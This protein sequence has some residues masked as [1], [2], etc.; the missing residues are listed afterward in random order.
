MRMRLIICLA[1]VLSVLMPSHG[2]ADVI[3]SVLDRGTLRVGV[4]LFVPWTFNGTND[5]LDGFDIAVAKQLAEDMG[6][7]AEF[8]VYSLDAILSGLEKEEIDVIAAGLAITPE[9][10]LRVNFTQPYMESGISLAANKK[11]TEQIKSFEEL[12]VTANKIGAVQD[13]LA[14]DFSKRFFKNAKI[15]VFSSVDEAE[16]AVISGG[17]TVYVA[18]VPAVNFLA[19]EH[20]DVIDAPLNKPLIASKAG[21]AVKKGEQEWLNFLNSWI[22]SRTANKWLDTTYKY[23][24]E[25]IDWT[26]DVKR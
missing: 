8:K 15:E 19:L 1:V 17:V 7:Q 18:S 16:K 13:T 5:Q 23:W 14:M 21:L 9:R 4:S 2:L 25:T 20:P 22:I 10:A 26:G 12:D 6:V 24:F 3:K 11:A